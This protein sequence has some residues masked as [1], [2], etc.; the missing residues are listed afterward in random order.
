MIKAL[1]LDD[2]LIHGQVAISWTRGLDINLLLVINDEVMNDEIRKM[3]LKMGVPSG[4]KYGFRTVEK[5]IEFL[6]NPEN[7]KYNIMAL[8]NNPIDAYKI[9]MAVPEIKKLTIG[10]LRKNA[11]YIYDNLN[12]DPED[13][14]ALKKIIAHGIPVGMQPTPDNKFVDLEKYLDTPDHTS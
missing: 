1:H 13:I 3:S 14:Q 10:G 7:Q 12:L 4:V 5:G 6:N 11:Q 2:R 8:I 9:C